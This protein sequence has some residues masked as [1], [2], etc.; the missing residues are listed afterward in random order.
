MRQQR[1][2]VLNNDY[3]LKVHYHPRNANVIANAISHEYRCNH[4]FVQSPHS[5]C[6]PE[7]SS[8][9]VVPQGSL[10]NIALISTIKEDVIAAQKIYVGM[11]HIR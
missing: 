10:N 4:L 7:E 3:E 6:D 11:E 2:L 5:C 1:W 8:L 9:R